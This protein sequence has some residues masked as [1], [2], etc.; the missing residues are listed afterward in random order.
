MLPP[1]QP[2]RLMMVVSTVE[3][4]TPS[5][6]DGSRDEIASTPCETGTR[7]SEKPRQT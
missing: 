6:A 5:E 2:T 7:R 3:P 1:N 4:S